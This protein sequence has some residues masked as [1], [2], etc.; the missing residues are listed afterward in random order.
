M[1]T[2]QIVI[3]MVLSL[4][5][6]AASAQ[7]PYMEEVKALGAIAG[8]GLAC[9]ASK[10]D[11]F[12]LLARAILLTKSPSDKLQT[13]AIYVY[14]EEKADVYMSKELDG[15]YDCAN[16]NRRFDNQ[17]IFKAVLYGDGTIKMPDGKILTPRK[18][19][20]ARL[21]YKNNND[22]KAAQAIYNGKKA[23]IT[24]VNV[25]DD[26]IASAN[27]GLPVPSVKRTRR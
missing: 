15:F 10:Y 19:Y 18:P 3:A 8:Q 26:H 24:K 25:V 11:D 9:G 1:K 22:R 5:A 23:T 6:N 16:I 14:S 13:D 27:G 2:K 21:I 20:D 12:E 17:E 7:M 4:I